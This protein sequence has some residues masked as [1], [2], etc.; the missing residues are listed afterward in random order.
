MIEQIRK[1]GVEW[2]FIR[3]IWTGDESDK[4]KWLQIKLTDW[5]FHPTDESVDVAV[6]ASNLPDA[7]DHLT[8][9]ISRIVS[10][11][12]L[13][14]G[15]VGH[16]TEVFIPGLFAKHYGNEKNIPIV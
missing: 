16:G 3:I 10:E 11:E 7:C 5:Q 12:M 13:A 1:T 15:Q 8:Y 4:L 14:N 6:F 2:T 9:P